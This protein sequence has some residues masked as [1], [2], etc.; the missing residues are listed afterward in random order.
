[1]RNVALNNTQAKFV[2]LIDVD[3]LPKRDLYQSI[4]LAEK[5]GSLTVAKVC[6]SVKN[7]LRELSSRKCLL[8]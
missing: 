5:S 8:N 7:M 3:F 1:M 4:L 6:M 2:F